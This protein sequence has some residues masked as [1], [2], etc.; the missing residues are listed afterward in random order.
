LRFLAEVNNAPHIMPIYFT[1]I[2]KK[3]MFFVQKV[4]SLGKQI[5]R[6]SLQKKNLNRLGVG[7]RL[8]SNLIKT[9]TYSWSLKVNV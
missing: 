3:K 7:L 5:A 9:T 6:F 8:K 4:F 2:Q 1:N